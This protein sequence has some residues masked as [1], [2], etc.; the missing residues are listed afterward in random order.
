MTHNNLCCN[1]VILN[2]CL[3]L[4][5]NKPDIETILRSTCKPSIKKTITDKQYTI[6][7]GE[8]AIGIEYAAKNLEGT[9]PVYFASFKSHFAVFFKLDRSTKK[10]RNCPIEVEYGEFQKA[11]PRLINKFIPYFPPVLSFK[12]N[13]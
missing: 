12:L 4:P 2:D 3:T 9:Q 10:V 11:G 1:Q 7:Y 8:L 13:F 5:D 6:I